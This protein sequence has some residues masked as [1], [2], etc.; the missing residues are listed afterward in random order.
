MLV[1]AEKATPVTFTRWYEVIGQFESFDQINSWEV[2]NDGNGNKDM[3][4]GD[5]IY[6]D[7]K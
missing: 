5:L 1:A 6:K 4:P 3:L 7:V 2:N